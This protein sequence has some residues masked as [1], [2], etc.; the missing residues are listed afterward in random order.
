MDGLSGV[1]AGGGAP[2]AFAAAGDRPH[3]KDT[4]YPCRFLLPLPAVSSAPFPLLLLIQM[5][6]PTRRSTPTTEPM[7]AP[8]ITPPLGL[9]LFLLG[10]SRSAGSEV[11]V[12]SADDDTSLELATGVASVMI[13]F[14]AGV[15]LETPAIKA[16]FLV[17][18]LR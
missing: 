10:G 16:R 4:V 1:V 7:T 18:L 11:V 3:A 14:T 8:A 2:S 6:I 15:L 13:A 5:P 9:L 12:D 17:Y